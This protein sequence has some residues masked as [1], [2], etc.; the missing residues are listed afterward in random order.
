MLEVLKGVQNQ[1]I[2]FLSY[3]GVT[4]FQFQFPLFVCFILWLTEREQTNFRFFYS[5]VASKR[6]LPTSS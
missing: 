5:T 4:Y 6:N 1:T 2:I 3:L